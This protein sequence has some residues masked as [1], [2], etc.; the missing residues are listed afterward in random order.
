M[1]HLQ[2]HQ[3]GLPVFQ[4]IEQIEKAGQFFPAGFLQW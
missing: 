1:L 2:E 4:H 3:I